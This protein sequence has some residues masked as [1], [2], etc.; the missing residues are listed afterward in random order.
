[1]SEASPTKQKLDEFRVS[2]PPG[3]E[4]TEPVTLTNKFRNGINITEATP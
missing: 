1:M 3:V 4:H 2:L